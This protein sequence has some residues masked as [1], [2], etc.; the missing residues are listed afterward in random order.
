MGAADGGAFETEEIF[1]QA[2]ETDLEC[3][4]IFPCVNNN[5]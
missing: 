1:G 5:T 4:N 3:E 2:I